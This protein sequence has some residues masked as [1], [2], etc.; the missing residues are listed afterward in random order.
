MRTPKQGNTMKKLI[1][2][3]GIASL[4]ILALAA[5]V[6][7]AGPGPGPGRGQG[8]AATAQPAGSAVAAILGMTHAEIMAQRHAGTSL[9][10]VAETKGVDPVKVVD[11][12][13][14]QWTAR[15]DARVA[16]GALTAAEAAQLRSEVQLR[17]KDMVYRTTRGG[18]QGAAVGGGRGTGMGRGAGAGSGACDGTGAMGGGRFGTTQP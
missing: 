18:M 15:I 5:T 17:A 1:G 2:S 6:V 7:A 3:I 8:P 16:A 12:V 13:A 9:A 4:A 11:A 14:D 10:Q